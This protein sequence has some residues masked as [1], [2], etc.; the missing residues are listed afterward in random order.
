MPYGVG[1]PFPQ[2]PQAQ[3]TTGPFMPQAP[4]PQPQQ[5]MGGY[6]GMGGSDSRAKLTQAVMEAMQR[7]AASDAVNNPGPWTAMGNAASQMAGAYVNRRNGWTG[8][9]MQKYKSKMPAMGA[10]KMTP[11]I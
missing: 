8:P 11:K 4:R 3:Q 7:K 2:Q 10:P 6:G 1:Q 9:Q 5:P